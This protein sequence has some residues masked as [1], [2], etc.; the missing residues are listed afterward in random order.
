MASKNIL[1]V[2]PC[3]ASDGRRVVMLGCSQGLKRQMRGELLS[4]SELPSDSFSLNFCCNQSFKSQQ[5]I[6]ICLALKH[7]DRVSWS[8]VNILDFSISQS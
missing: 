2:S 4:V 8:V 6:R 3:D 1:Q 5:Q 7:L